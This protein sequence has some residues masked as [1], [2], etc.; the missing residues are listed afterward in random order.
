MEEHIIYDLIQIP[1]D[2]RSYEPKF[3]GPFTVRE[4]VCIAIAGAIMLGGV[5]IENIYFRWIPFLTFRLLFL[6]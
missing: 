3:L 1:K 6:P 5:A 4:G 2:I